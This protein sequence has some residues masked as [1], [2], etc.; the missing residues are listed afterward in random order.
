MSE[1]FQDAFWLW[2]QS[3]G[4]HHITAK[5]PGVNR[6]TPI[7]C[8]REFGI[9]NCYRVVMSGF[10][11]KPYD[12]EAEALAE[13]RQVVWS[14]TGSLDTKRNDD[15]IG[16]LYETLRLAE[17]F[18][19][20]T[21]GVL[22]DFFNRSRIGFFPPE[23]LAFMREKLH[24]KNLKL[25]V[26]V[27]DHELDWGIEKHLAECD[28]I[29]F[30]TWNGNKNLRSQEENFTKLQ[31]MAPGKKFSAGFYM[32]DYRNSTTLG[33]DLME[34]Q[35]GNYLKWYKDGRI[36]GL[37]LCSN[38]IADIGLEASPWTKEWM[39]SVAGETR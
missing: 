29:T 15:G 25:H 14:I 31:K 38:C 17:K 12:P 36:D 1:K 21:G 3:P 32:W 7:E 20:F 27:Y 16:D 28:V 33:L 2:G 6:M 23:K 9:P 30:W 18:P 8:C 26:V 34:F 19:N 10:P 37:I 35:C 24:E 4:S 13:C 39:K 11:N 5:L 22:D